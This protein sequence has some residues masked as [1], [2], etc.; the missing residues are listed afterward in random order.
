[1]CW[2]VV[3][4]PHLSIDTDR[5]D[6]SH[7]E[8]EEDA[9]DGRPYAHDEADELDEE[10]K[11]REHGNGNVVV[12]ETVEACILLVLKGPLRG[13]MTPHTDLVETYANDHTNGTWGAGW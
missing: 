1:M 7:G 13:E 12:C 9:H 8:A 2:I 6:D 4:R 5:V 11:Q 3:V 10:D